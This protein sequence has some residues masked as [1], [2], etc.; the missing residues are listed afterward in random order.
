MAG[1]FP[2]YT[3]ADIQAAVVKALVQA[4]WDILRAIDAYAE[5]TEDLTHFER[6][7]ALGRVLV[8]NDDDQRQLARRFYREGRPFP[9]LIWWP[10]SQYQRMRPGDVVRRFEEYAAQGA[11]FAAY[12]ILQLEPYA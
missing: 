11:P 3:D 7:I 6:A 10:Q 1:Y 2:L 5:G 9:G 12:P 4:G 8:S